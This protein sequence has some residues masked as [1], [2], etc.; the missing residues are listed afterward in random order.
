M[1]DKVE[2]ANRLYEIA[3]S[4]QGYFTA[5]QARDVGIGD[6]AHPYHVE[7]GNWIREWRGIYRLARF[8][9]SEDSHLVLWSLWSRNRNGNI[10]G[11]YS[12]ETAL[13]I[14]EL[15]DANPDKLHMIVPSKFRRTADV[16]KVLRLHKGNIKPED[17][18]E[19]L[20]Y[21]VTKPF[22]TILILIEEGTISEE[23]IIQALKDG[24]TKGYLIKKQMMNAEISE[25]IRNKIEMYLEQI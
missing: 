6:N 10:Q 22:S 24:I 13:S 8:P 3:V 20:G 16:P 25:P 1:H 12:H 17:C 21:K 7:K 11:V 5:S 14:F 4:Q 15:S 23:I 19:R 2:V 9:E 18:E